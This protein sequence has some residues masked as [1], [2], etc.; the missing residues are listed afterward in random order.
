LCAKVL[1]SNVRLRVYVIS[2]IERRENQRGT[3]AGVAGAVTLLAV[4]ALVDLYRLIADAA[5]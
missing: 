5:R 1:V 3:I 4:A 2:Q